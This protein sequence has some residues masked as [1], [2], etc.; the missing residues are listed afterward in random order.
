MKT[1]G[2]FSPAQIRNMQEHDTIEAADGDLIKGRNQKWSVLLVEDDYDDRVI[3]IRVLK[4]SSQI[5]D[6]YSFSNGE[7]LI[8]HLR[9]NGYFEA[10]ARG[11]MPP[12]MIILDIHIPGQDGMELLTLLKNYP[13]T[14]T[15]P[16]MI[17]TG[18]VM[19]DYALQAYRLQANGFICKPMTD[20]HLK[21]IHAVF[22]AG[23]G[24]SVNPQ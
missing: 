3:A 22:E 11:E 14:R 2:T 17:V 16:V 13:L 21:E 1:M 23:Q 7:E 5:G 9:Q 19:N 15:L 8:R 6:V 10:T 18:D 12:T 24:W 20:H 4:E